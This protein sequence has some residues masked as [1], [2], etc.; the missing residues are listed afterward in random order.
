[1]KLFPFAV[2]VLGIV[3]GVALSGFLVMQGSRAAFTD[4]TDNTGN[5][6]TAGTVDLVDDDSSTVLFNVSNMAP[7]DSSTNCIV[8]TYQGSIANP[9]AV[10]LYTGGLT[11]SSDLANWLDVTIEEGTGGS[12]GDCSGFVLQNSIESGGDLIAFNTTHTDYASGAGVWDPSGTPESK[13]Y[14]FTFALDAA[15]PDTEE[16]ASVTALGFTWEVQSN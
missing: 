7:G 16:G 11:D 15:T 10:K 13:T 5:S 9:A 6:F 12:F 4:T 1:M 14:R 8:V 3:G 2:P